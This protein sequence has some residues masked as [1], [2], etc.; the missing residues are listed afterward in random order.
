MSDDPAGRSLYHADPHDLAAGLDA[1]VE[2]DTLEDANL[3]GSKSRY[4]D[5]HLPVLDIDFPARLVPSTTE[6]HFHLYLDIPLTWEKYQAVLGVLAW[7]GILQQGYADKSIRRQQSFV[8]K[9]GVAKLPWEMSSGET[10]QLI[11]LVTE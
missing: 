6:G 7:A 11:G 1:R 8:C 10:P 3:I 2:V 4:C 9:P 5:L